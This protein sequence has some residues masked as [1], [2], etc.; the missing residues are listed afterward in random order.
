[1]HAPRL[2]RAL[3]L[4]SEPSRLLPCTQHHLQQQ[5]RYLLSW[6]FGPKVKDCDHSARMRSGGA[7]LPVPQDAQG[8]SAVRLP[9][10]LSDEDITRILRVSSDIR[11]DGAGAV[12]LQSSPSMATDGSLPSWDQQGYE[13][14][15]GTWSTTYLQTEYM[16]QNRLPELHKRVKDA[17]V[18]VDRENWGICK[19]ALA[20]GEPGDKLNT[21]YLRPRLFLLHSRDSSV[22]N[23]CC[24]DDR[25]IELHTVGPTGGLPAAKHY[26]SGSVVTVDLMLAEPD[27]GGTFE[28]LELID[29]K[30]TKVAHEFRR[31]DA[32][33]FPS[34]K[35]HSVQ[36]VQAGMR[37]VMIFE[38][39]VGEERRC[40]HRCEQHFGDCKHVRTF[41]HNTTGS[42]VAW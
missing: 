14:D 35:Y 16:F 29:G 42:S 15:R 26:D 34:H 22:L 11:R 24:L 33:V 20:A 18:R 32:M 2:A 4:R 40:N 8:M 27:S 3:R 28:T 31:G 38:F 41:W 21:R 13:T 25:V 17:A 6:L 9:E 1:M 39:W 37:Q 10:F 23:V 7:G 5:R 36:P 30:E 12:R 19:A